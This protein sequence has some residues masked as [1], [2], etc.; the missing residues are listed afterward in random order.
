MPNIKRSAQKSS[1]I[2]F[3]K[4]DPVPPFMEVGMYYG[5]QKTITA[6]ASEA[7]WDL[8]TNS[9]FD[10]DLT[11]TGSQPV[12]FDQWSALYSRYRV[13]ATRVHVWASNVSGTHLQL[14]VAPFAGSNSTSSYYT[15]EVAAWR[16]SHAA[17]FNSGGPVAHLVVDI[18]PDRVWGGS[19]ASLLNDDSYVAASSASPG[20]TSSLAIHARSSGTTDSVWISFRMEFVV[21]FETPTFLTLSLERRSPLLGDAPKKQEEPAPDRAGRAPVTCTCGHDTCASPARRA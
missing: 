20:R 9:L 12:F 18:H 1:T 14:A 6:A 21:R 19:A 10:P 13:L 5:D 4:L 17:A 2:R 15:E 7:Y 3:R 11:Y 16:N 8:R